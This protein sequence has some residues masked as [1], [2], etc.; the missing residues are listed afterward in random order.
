MVNQSQEDLTTQLKKLIFMATREGLYDAADFIQRSIVVKKP[1]AEFCIGCKN[2]RMPIAIPPC[3]KCLIH[4][5]H[6]FEKPREQNKEIV[7]LDG[8]YMFKNDYDW[9]KIQLEPKDDI[10][11]VIAMMIGNYIYDWKKQE[12]EDKSEV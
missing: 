7:K 2:E 11:F 5:G 12:A 4:G 10:N 8:L 3:P 1:K 9:L 6:S